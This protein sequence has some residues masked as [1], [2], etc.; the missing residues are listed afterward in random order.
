MTVIVVGALGC[1]GGGGSSLSATGRD[2]ANGGECS[3][4]AKGQTCTGEDA[5]MSCIETA[6]GVQFKACLGNNYAKGDFTGGACAEYMTCQM[7]CPCDA[8]ANTC[9]ATCGQQYM[10]AGTCATCMTT[11]SACM[12]A[13]ACTE[14]VCT[15]TP[16]TGAT[17]STG[18]GTGTGASC[19]ALTACCATISDAN[20]AAACKSSQTGGAEQTCALMIQGF[21]SLGYCK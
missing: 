11:L 5:Y 4:S 12:T 21:Q 17:T 1:G 20:I 14:P 13:A 9:A 2:P 16:T 3:G 10:M 6:C 18:T 8:T 19:K 7:A 15:A